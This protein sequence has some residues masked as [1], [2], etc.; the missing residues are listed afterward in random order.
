VAETSTAAPLAAAAP[1]AAEEAAPARVLVVEDE[2]IIAA[3]IAR[4]LA[5]RGFSVCGI[6]ATGPAAIALAAEQQPDLVLMD[7]VLPGQLDGIAAAQVIRARQDV[8]VV[9]LTAYAEDSVVRRAMASGPAGYLVK[10]FEDGELSRTVEIALAQHRLER[11][12]RESE[13]WL[14]TTLASIDEAVVATGTDGLVSYLNPAAERLL[15]LGAQEAQGR[16]LAEVVPLR[17][18]ATLQSAAP[19]LEEEARGKLPGGLRGDFLFDGPG[20]REVAVTVSGAPIVD[21]GGRLLGAVLA[22]RDDSAQKAAERELFRS[23]EELRRHVG[24]IHERNAALRV[25]LE[26]RELD[27]LEFEE[28]IME[29]L[30]HLVL[31]Y[32]EKL[33]AAPRDQQEAATLR[34]LRTNLEQLV[35]PFSRRLSSRRHGLTPQEL[36]IANLIRDGRQDKEIVDV[37]NISFET[38]KTHRQNIRKKLGI[39]GTGSSLRDH[40]AQFDN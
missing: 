29:N 23:R 1:A 17:D 40:L 25:L 26:Q 15:G 8:P 16:P 39:Y 36:R 7:I 21:R 10:P 19:A 3:D 30:R 2:A 28:R 5:A 24:E 13:K 9:F 18:A 31:P 32:L 11:R 14:A 22:I 38:V 20:G 12:V 27:R 35:S 34:L 33:A 6:A 37:L 4:R